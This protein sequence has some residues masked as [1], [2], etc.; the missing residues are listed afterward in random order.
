MPFSKNNKLG[1]G[2]PKGAKNKVTH[3]IKQAMGD[4]VG[5]YLGS[6]QAKKD[7]DKLK[8]YERFSLIQRMSAPLIPREYSIGSFSTTTEAELLAMNNQELAEFRENYIE[9]RRKA[10]RNGAEIIINDEDDE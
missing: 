7:W 9:Q 3:K 1:T 2:R 5:T 6:E 10:L 8:P 4:F